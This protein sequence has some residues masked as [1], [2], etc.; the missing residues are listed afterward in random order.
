MLLSGTPAPNTPD[1][2]V[3]LINLLCRNKADEMTKKVWNN[4]A[5]TTKQKIAFMKNRVS[6]F[7][8]GAKFNY[9]GNIGGDRVRPRK[10][11]PGFLVKNVRVKLS[12]DQKTR[13]L[14]LERKILRESP[15]EKEK[16]LFFIRERKIVYKGVGGQGATPKIS[17]VASDIA[18]EMKKSHAT[19]SERPLLHGRLLVYV[20]NH[21]TR[22]ALVKEIKRVVGTEEIKKRSID[23]YSGRT[24]GATRARIKKSF[25]EGKTDVLIISSGG[26][27]GLDLQCTSKVFV[28]DM[29]WNIPQ[30][31]QIIGRAIRFNSH[32][33]KK[34]GC[35]HRHV[36]V[37]VYT[38]VLPKPR[39]GV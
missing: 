18:K 20:E 19:A 27:V 34:T 7:N 29:S 31:N 25:N 11:L 28:L 37:Y 26:A 17:R 32:S 33:K 8:I 1:D 21:E 14:A 2:I 9:V 3:P 15:E 39:N 36:D 4:K 30:M 13:Y 35:K 22:E 5:T 12:D 24:S 38:S 10:K 6:V 16:H 23:E